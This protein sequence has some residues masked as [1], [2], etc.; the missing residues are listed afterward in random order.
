[1]TKIDTRQ[2]YL[3]NIIR[4]N[5]KMHRWM[6]ECLLEIAAYTA[7]GISM[8]FNTDIER[9]LEEQIGYSIFFTPT[10]SRVKAAI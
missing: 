1:M 9:C 2:F 7:K 5:F 3:T 4:A 10:K 8:K 6:N